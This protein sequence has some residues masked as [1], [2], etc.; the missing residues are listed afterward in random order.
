MPAY[1]D[2]LSLA[3]TRDKLS[4]LSSASL[5]LFNSA[6]FNASSSNTPMRFFLFSIV[7][8]AVIVRVTACDTPP[9]PSPAPSSSPACPSSFLSS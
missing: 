7:G 5:S 9:S 1:C 3:P 4:S 6:C 2:S 8:A